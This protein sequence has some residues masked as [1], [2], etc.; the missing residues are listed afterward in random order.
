MK[1]VNWSK[2]IE[3][4]FEI[5]ERILKR[6]K[7]PESL[8]PPVKPEIDRFYKTA[9]TVSEELSLIGIKSLYRRLDSMYCYTDAI[10]WVEAMIYIYENEEMP[11]YFVK[12]DGSWNYDCEDHAIWLK[13]M[14]S[15][16]FGLNYFGI[17]FGTMPQGEHGFNL[18]RD[19]EGI[20]MYEPQPGYDI[21]Y[22]FLPDDEHGYK[23]REAL[24]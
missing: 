7:T 21:N 6:K 10:G 3:A 9:H 24:V 1:E 17:V 23:P 22:P 5:I 13:A 11:K 19:E 12:L 2:V 4:I 14:V 16:H 18:L 20:K 15:K 8:P